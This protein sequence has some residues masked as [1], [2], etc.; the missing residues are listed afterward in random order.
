MRLR[1]AESYVAGLIGPRRGVA[2]GLKIFSKSPW[3]LINVNR[4]AVLQIKG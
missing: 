1:P 3:T 2:G 4:N